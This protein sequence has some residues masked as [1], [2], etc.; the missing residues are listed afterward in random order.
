VRTR[1]FVSDQ[2]AS[3][4]R[5]I[6]EHLGSLAG[7]DLAQR[8]RAGTL[9]AKGRTESRRE[10]KRDLTALSSSRW[11]GSLTRTSEDAFGLARRNLVAEAHSLSRRMATI[12]KRLAIPV[13][14]RQGGGRR[15]GGRGGKV[16]GYASAAE[17]FEK[18]R[19][20]QVLSA[21]RA[22]VESCLAHGK[23][24]VCRGGRRLARTHHHLV[25][26][27]LSER[28]W[29]E[30][31]RAERLFLTADG[32]A[33]KTFGNETI[34][35]HPDQGW[36]E[37]KVPTPLSHLANRPFGR[38]RLSCP[39]AF[40][41]RGGEVGAQAATGAVRYDIAFSAEKG[42]WYLDASWKTPT[43]KAPALSELRGHPV[44]A[45]DHNAGHLAALVT[46]SSGNPV[47]S[48]LTLNV[49][50]AGLPAAT[51][52]GHLR[53]AVSCLI[54]TATAY[55]C[56]A[57]V[58]EDLDFKNARI[59]GREQTGRRP[60]R[61]RRGKS[62]RALVAGMP[63]AKFRDRL[64]QMV[65]NTG[66]SVVA[67][68]PAYTS[69]WGAEH[70]L[71]PLRNISREASGHHAAALVIGRRGLAQRARRRERSDSD[72]AAHGERELPTPPCGP[73]QQRLV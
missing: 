49:E 70:W 5:A 38:Y 16:S 24:S 3:V 60:S 2:D 37:L 33:D 52:D 35:F 46:D 56:H 17:R 22:Q 18:Q 39:V 47:G 61:G 67:V 54:A 64:V 66:L 57:I 36:L 48:P 62:F 29:H 34:R 65:T 13:G 23:V 9:D 14:G 1:L 41:H 59:E 8:C 6:G 73:H 12:T 58:I 32:E 15:V 19:R 25:Q 71:A 45:L 68:D 11:A 43:K 30:R 63:T 4:L 42:R 7:A 40:S 69:R 51:R 27:G 44:L 26:A 10:R 31:W 53:E 50:G 72:P 21:R 20:C 55:G 28:E